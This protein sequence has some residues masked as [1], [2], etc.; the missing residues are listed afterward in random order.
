MIDHVTIENME[1]TVMVRHISDKML[2]IN[3]HCCYGNGCFVFTCVHTMFL[4]QAFL[5]LLKL[6]WLYLNLID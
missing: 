6:Q 1:Q 4:F 3:S 5:I 2:Y